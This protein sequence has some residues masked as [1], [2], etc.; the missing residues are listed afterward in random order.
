MSQVEREVSEGEMST[1]TGSECS[2]HDRQSEEET[3]PKGDYS[4]AECVFG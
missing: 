4:H 1:E 2:D 3:E